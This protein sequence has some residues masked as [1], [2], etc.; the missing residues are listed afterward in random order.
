I[1]AVM[2]VVT[3]DNNLRK[4]IGNLHYGRCGFVPTMGALHEGHLALIRR[5]QELARPVVVSIFVN[6]TQFGPGEDYQRY[7]RTFDADVAAAKE[8]GAEIVFAPEIETVY[9]GFPTGQ[10][11][12]PTTE[13]PPV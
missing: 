6:P 3:T 8:A 7:P 9:P 11:D 2:Q 1:L 13:L 5:A 10:V 4:A 12:L